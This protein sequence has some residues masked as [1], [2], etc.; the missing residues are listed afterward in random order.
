M[1]ARLLALTLL[2]VGAAP[3]LLG[4][5][6]GQLDTSFESGSFVDGVVTAVAPA[7]G[8]K[9]YIGGDFTTVRGALRNDIARLNADGSADPS[10]NPGSGFGPN[11]V[12]DALAVLSDGKVLVVGGFT[13]Y[14]GTPCNRIARLNAN[15]SLDASFTPGSGASGRILSLALQPDGKVLIGGNFTSY[16]GTPRHRI[17]RLNANGSLDTSFN[18][19]SGANSSVASLAVR[20][21]GKVLLGG[22]FTSYNGTPRH[23]VARLNANGS[24]DTDFDPG[25]GA[26]D[27]ILSLAPLPDGKVLIGGWFTSYGGT[28][29][30]RIT[31]L[32]ANGSL[33][34]SFDPGSG[35]NAAAYS[36]AVQSDGRVLFGGRFTSYDGTERKGLARLNSD[37]SLDTTFDPATGAN[38]EVL[39]IVMQSDGKVLLG[40]VFLNHDSA[41][42]DGVARLNSDGSLD[43]SFIPGS[44]ANHQILS[45][46]AQPDGKVLLGG[47]FTG[48]GGTTRNRI[49]RL[50]T[51][52]SL[53]PSFDPG[54]GANH[55]ILSLAVQPDGKVLVVGWFTN[56]GG[57]A[58]NYI[59]RLNTDGSLDTDFAP[60][61]GANHV[62]SSFALQ[63]DGK[64]LVSGNFTSYNGTA[65]NYIARL[66][67]DGSLDTSFNPGSGA[68]SPVSSF[69]VQPDGK[70]LI[71]GGFTSYNGTARHRIARLNPDGSLDTS[72]NPGSGADGMVYSLAVQSDGKVLLGGN[73]TSYDGVPR[74]RIVRLN[75][76][77]SLD[78]SFDPGSGANEAV[79][80]IAVQSDGKVLVGGYFTNYN[81]TARHRIA[82]LNADGS[83]DTSF[84]PG[85]GANN[86]VSALALQPDGKVLVGGSFT[87]YNGT[88]RSFLLRTA[89]DPAVQV[90]AASS[91]TQMRWLR[92]GSAPVA[93][94]VTFEYSPNGET[95]TPLGAATRIGGGWEL[96]GLSLPSTGQLRARGRS[97]G[98]SSIVEQSVVYTSYSPAPEISVSGNGTDI[99]SGDSTPGAADHTDFGTTDGSVTRTFT[100]AN[101]GPG[102]LALTGIPTV[103]LDGSPAFRVVQPPASPLVAAWSGTQTFQIA[104]AP[105]TPGPH[106][107]TV[108]IASSDADENPF[109]FA[110]SG[111]ADLSDN[112]DLSGLSLS[113]GTLA[114]AFA[115]GTP[116]YSA[117]VGNPTVSITATRAQAN[118]TLHLR[119][120]GGSYMPIASG[121][122]S[123]PLAL[124]LGANTVDVRVTAHAE[125]TQTY[126]IAVARLE[127]PTVSSPTSTSITATGATLGGNV[128]TDGE[129]PIVERGI[130]YSVSTTNASPTIGGT[131][132]MKAT[133]SGTTGAF[134]VPV[135]ELANGTV[136]AF[137]AYATNSEGTGYSA[138]AT[139]VTD[140]RVTFNGGTAT[141]VRFI[142]PGE[143]HR[144]EFAL[145]GPRLVSLS[146]TSGAVL[147]AELRD[148]AGKVVAVSNSTAGFVLDGPLLAGDYVLEVRRPTGAGGAQSYT[149]ALDAGTVAV[150]RPDVAVGPSLSR[151]VGRNAHTGLQQ[152]V[153]AS[154][155]ARPV[156]AHAAIVN[157]GSLP[158]ALTVRAGKGNGFFKVAYFAPG[159][160]TA[161]LLSGS[162]R[163]PVL[164]SGD[165]EAAIRVSVKPNKRKLTKKKG[166]KNTILK[167]T[168]NL[169]V[170]AESV[171]NP[172]AKDKATIRVQVK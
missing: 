38:S 118:A 147:G 79:D 9:V 15:G 20:S 121:S 57:T 7:G 12:V 144:F 159:N 148:A 170:A 119:V 151:L 16:N 88:A 84:N 116:H 120:N 68:S 55:S 48:Y 131:G 51:D 132:V 74:N 72:F 90:L 130:V 67:A 104:F 99:T 11:S 112:A 39:S 154:K 113:G 91:P 43:P 69:F 62:I 107:A 53:D 146:A 25:S 136:Y 42:A 139:F 105:T 128:V 123:S 163:T 13:S 171:S 89:N 70:V 81:D 19:G 1:N 117:S 85:S 94:Q 30:H 145:A 40:G 34:P 41:Y 58:R 102:L 82:R 127:R 28:A 166:G 143:S 161:A 32:N 101:S 126:T 8:G 97:N 76:D 65:R 5:T 21:D 86:T 152:S 64:V 66:N 96:S 100:I 172:A 149:L 49:A 45:L 108:S 165:A 87:I 6:P 92:G 138:V 103:A 168:L 59:A 140:T 155:K 158:D 35:A 18:S 2:F 78:T 10:F 135:T 129:A 83:L 114:P 93:E 56:Y 111:E 95:W 23:R 142:S 134:T 61:S 47:G 150:P 106:A 27:A 36:L 110:I 46:A 133:A 73:F 24:L 160:V 80:S 14:N 153:L 4:Q 162:H 77:G 71:G 52:G 98:S 122:P 156:T 125:N 141:Y 31:R 44:G 63:L 3:P 115:S 60:G 22:A 33:D 137:K 37:G 169:P 26:N 167:K 157:R 29:R 75:A 124:T 54:S 17:A 50:N 109:T 164:K